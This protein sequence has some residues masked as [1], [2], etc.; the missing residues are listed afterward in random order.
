MPEA[1]SSQNGTGEQKKQ[2]RKPP[3]NRGLEL[4]GF[5]GGGGVALRLMGRPYTHVYNRYVGGNVFLK[6]SREEAALPGFAASKP[7]LPAPY[8]AGHEWT[9]DCYWRAWEIAFVNLRQPPAQS[10]LI[11]NFIDTA[12]ND[13]TFLWDSCFMTMFGRYGAR[14]FS[15][16][17]TLDNFYARQHWDG[18]ICREIAI[19]DG[20]DRFE[21]FDPAST[22]PNILPW[23]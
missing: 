16:Q 14:A 4:L 5:G 6:R 7:L 21:R 9:I 20:E 10:P 3:G 18:F 11:A 15:F 17:R 19:E 8:W 13:C 1:A 23:A 2:R 12:F 22:G